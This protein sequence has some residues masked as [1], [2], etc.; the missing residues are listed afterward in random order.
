[1]SQPNT[2]STWVWSDMVMGRTSH[3]PHPTNYKIV[4]HFRA[5][6]SAYFLYAILFQLNSNKCVKEKETIWLE[7]R[8]KSIQHKHTINQPKST[9]LSINLVENENSAAWGKCKEVD[10][11]LYLYRFP[12]YM[13]F[14]ESFRSTHNTIKTYRLE[15]NFN[16]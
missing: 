16:T 4:R 6:Y 3:Q 13:V 8:I 14:S 15:F 1:M 9:K 11:N 5:I 2:I 7:P 10:L 12:S